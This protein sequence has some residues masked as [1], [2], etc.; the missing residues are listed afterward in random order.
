M[1]SLSRNSTASSGN[2]SVASRRAWAFGC[3]SA[4]PLVCLDELPGS[5]RTSWERR[6]LCGCSA[7]PLRN[8]DGSGF[9]LGCS[10]AQ[11]P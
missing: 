2:N 11:L 8:R 4:V 3:Q 1:P 10:P 6:F 5:M 7:R 9:D